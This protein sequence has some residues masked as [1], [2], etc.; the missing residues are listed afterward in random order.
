LTTQAQ[1]P[2]ICSQCEAAVHPDTTECLDCGEPLDLERERSTVSSPARRRRVVSPARRRAALRVAIR[3]Y[4]E[5]G[6]VVLSQTST[7]AQLMRKKEFSPGL[8]LLGW[9]FGVGF[10]NLLYYVFI[11]QDEHIYLEIGLDGLATVI[12]QE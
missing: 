10:L 11:K 8:S 4:A 5:A 6:Y 2:L 7:T 3:M 12:E 9:L 1:Q